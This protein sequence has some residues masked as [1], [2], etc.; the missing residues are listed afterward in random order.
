MKKLTLILF[1]S[2]VI[3]AQD[4]YHTK[5]LEAIN[6]VQ[7]SIEFARITEVDKLDPYHYEKAK[8]SRDI[9]NILASIMDDVGAKIFLLKSFNAASKAMAGKY[10]L[11]ELAPMA[12]KKVK[13][14]QGLGVD[15]DPFDTPV[16][17]K[18][19]IDISQSLGVNLNLI[20][21]RLIEARNEKALTCTPVEL[22]RAEVYYDALLYELSKDTPISTHLTDFYQKGIREVNLAFEK[23][24]IAKRGNLECYT[25]KPFVSEVGKTEK[26]EEGVQKSQEEPVEEIQDHVSRKLLMATARVHFDFNKANIKRDYIPLLNEVVKILKE[27][28]NVRVKIEGFTDDIGSKTYNDKLALKRAQAIRDYLIKAGI[29]ADRIEVA[30]FGKERYIADNKTPM[31]RFTNRRVEFIVIQVPG[32]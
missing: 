23:I 9:A 17:V 2:T 31:E 16:P 7:R 24:K 22:A 19:E 18:K 25:G 3:F 5:L 12:S 15:L 4:L 6:Q 26:T 28:P 20:S 8:A 11:D 32:Q 13:T 21:E 1:V 29:P 14:E 27:N 30:G 10:Q